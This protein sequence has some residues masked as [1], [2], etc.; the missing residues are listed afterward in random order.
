M[1]SSLRS[2]EIRLLTREAHFTFAEQ[3][4]HSEAISLARRANFT[5]KGAESF[6]CRRR[7]L[8]TIGTTDK[9]KLACDGGI[10]VLSGLSSLQGDTLLRPPHPKSHAI[11]LLTGRRILRNGFEGDARHKTQLNQAV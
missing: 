1:K 2:D 10:S 4:F 11:P 8:G 6:R 3:I 7:D 9:S 5:E